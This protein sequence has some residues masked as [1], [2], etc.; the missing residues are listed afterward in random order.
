[1]D[2]WPAPSWQRLTQKRRAHLE[3]RRLRRA[4]RLVTVGAVLGDR[5]VLPEK[6]PAVFRM[7]AGAGLVD[8]VLHQLRRGGRA[9]RRMA[10]GAGHLAFAQRMMRRLE[11]IGVLRLVA[12][13]ADLDL[14]GRGS[15]P[16][17]WPHA[18]CGSSRMPRCSPRARSMPSRAPRSTGGSPD[19]SRFA[20]RRS[21]AL[22]AP[23]STM[24]AGGPPPAFTC[25]PP[26]PW[27]ASHCR[28]P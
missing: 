20:A 17:L 9:V 1:M 23:K 27:Q 13:G 8:G 7:A 11:K 21:R 28:P 4:V 26:G 12:A 22:W 14:G 16:D 19:I 10:G 25:A 18:A 6:R 3:K 2:G 24:P 15:A 5:L